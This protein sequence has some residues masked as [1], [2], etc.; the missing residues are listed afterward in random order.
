MSFLSFLPTLSANAR[1]IETLNGSQIDPTSARKSSVDNKTNS[2]LSGLFSTGSKI[3][4]YAAYGW[5]DKQL[6][7]QRNERA[8]AQLATNF[9]DQ[10]NGSGPIDPGLA[11]IAT[12]TGGMEQFYID[13]MKSRDYPSITDAGQ[14][15]LTG[16]AMKIAG[17]ALIAIIGLFL[18]W[19]K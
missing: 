17:L 8:N 11:A 13:P 10:Y 12:R 5:V 15:S 19:R 4:E 2:F 16:N 1:K 7:T 14:Q 3:A 9:W 18:I 6:G